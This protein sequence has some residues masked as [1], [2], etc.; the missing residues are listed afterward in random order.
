VATQAIETLLYGTSPTDPVTLAMVIG[1]LTTA[2]TLAC[3]APA[4]RAWRI[5]P[6]EALRRE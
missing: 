5:D 3:V 1:A 2:A 6:V 4:A